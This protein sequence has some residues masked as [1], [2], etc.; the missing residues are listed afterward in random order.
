MVA[1]TMYGIVF[2]GERLREVVDSMP[3]LRSLDVK[4]CWCIPSLS[5][6]SSGPITNTLTNLRLEQFETRLPIAELQRIQR[7]RALQR[8][9]LWNIFRRE[10]TAEEVTPYTPPSQLMPALR[11]FTCKC[12]TFRML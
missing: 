12:N 10:L 2:I 8:V 4:G 9:D 5:F 1:W 3:L 11:S 6:L 7:L